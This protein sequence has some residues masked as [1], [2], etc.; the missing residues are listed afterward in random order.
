MFYCNSDAKFTK[1]VPTLCN[2]RLNQ[3]LFFALPLPLENWK[4]NGFVDV[5]VQICLR[6]KFSMSNLYAHTYER[7]QRI[8]SVHKHMCKY[9]YNYKR[10]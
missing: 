9:K 1:H 2:H 4:L 3:R 7:V 8:I 5:E 10:K 6:L